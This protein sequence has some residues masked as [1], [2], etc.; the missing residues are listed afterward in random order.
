MAHATIRPQILTR[1]FIELLLRLLWADRTAVIR[2]S[3]TGRHYA[4]QCP[5][6]R[7]HHGAEVPR[8]EFV[9][10]V[11]VLLALGPVPGRRVEHQAE[12]TFAEL[13][14]ARRAVDDLAAVEVDVLL[15]AL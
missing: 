12:Q 3:L 4:R 2:S 5:A 1:C 14:D 6:R 11:A 13:L 8:D 7:S 15:L 10:P 9:L